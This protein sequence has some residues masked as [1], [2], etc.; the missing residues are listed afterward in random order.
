MGCRRTTIVFIAPMRREKRNRPVACFKVLCYSPLLVIDFFYR[1]D[2]ERVIS[3]QPAIDCGA[4]AARAV[5]R[6]VLALMAHVRSEARKIVVEGFARRSAYCLHNLGEVIFQRTFFRW[7][8]AAIAGS[9]AIDAV[10]ADFLLNGF[11]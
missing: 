10:R 2:D 4:Q 8:Q 1:F 9:I 5:F 6:L 3:I 11:P 7:M